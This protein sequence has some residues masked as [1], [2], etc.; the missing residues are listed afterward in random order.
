MYKEMIEWLTWGEDI[1]G[2]NQFPDNNEYYFNWDP[3]HE[4]AYHALEH[5]PRLTLG[6]YNRNDASRTS[7]ARTAARRQHDRAVADRHG[8]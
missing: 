7:R 4:D 3:I 2:N 8:L 5:Q 1:N 6:S